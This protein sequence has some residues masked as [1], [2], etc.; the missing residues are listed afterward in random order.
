MKRII[1]IAFLFCF[2]LPLTAQTN[3]ADKIV[4]KWYTEDN[5]SLVEIYKKGDKYFGKMIWLKNPLEDDGSI[6][7]DNE[8]PDESLRSKPLVGLVIMS[9]M[10]FD[11]GNEWEDGEIYDPESGDS[12]SCL[13]TLTS[14]DKIDMR[15][16]MGFSF[17]GRSTTWVRKKD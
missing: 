16:Y 14:P 12:Y 1:T 3:M 7:L 4:G 15:G 17:I 6:K 8:N 5:K 11:E 10:E 2:L 13:I 9:D